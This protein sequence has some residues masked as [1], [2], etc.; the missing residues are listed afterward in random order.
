[1]SVKGVR[2]FLDLIDIPKAELRRILDA[3]VAMKASTTKM[4]RN[5]TFADGRNLYHAISTTRKAAESRKSTKVVIT[6]DTGTISRG[7]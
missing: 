7:K 6:L 4:G 2:H 3:S 5:I 1:M